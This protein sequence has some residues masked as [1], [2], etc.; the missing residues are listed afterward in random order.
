MEYAALVDVYE[1]LGGTQSTLEKRDVLADAF[2]AADDEH[3]PLLV[4]LVRGHLFAAWRRED[5]DVSSS[6]T[7]RAIVKATGVEES[8]IDDRWRETGDLGDAAAWATENEAQRTLFSADLTVRDVYDTLRELTTY[9]GDGSQ[10]RRI[11]AIAR[12]LSDA[13]PEEARYVTRTAL[14]HLRIGVGD[15]LVRDAIAMAFLDG[16]DEDGSGGDA[17]DSDTTGDDRDDGEF[18][19]SDGSDGSDSGV[20]TDVGTGADTDDAD[21]A[22]AT[23]ASDEAVSDEAIGAVERAFQVTNDYP[24]VARTAENEGLDGLAELGISLFRPVRVMLAE[25]AE[26]LDDGIES[27]AETRESVLSEYKYDG[28]RIQI[29][30]RGEE[31]RIFTRRLEDVTDAFP[32]IVSA[33]REN[34]HAETCVLDGEAVGYDPETGRPVTFQRFSQRIKR[35]YDIEELAEEIPAVVYL[36]DA[37]ALEGDSLLDDPLRERLSALEG[38]FDPSEGTLERAHNER[39]SDPEGT[40]EF[41]EASLEAGHEGVMLKNLDAPY[42]P[43]RRVG[44]VMKAKPTMETLDLLVTRAQYSEGRR[45]DFLGR[46]F[47]ACIDDTGS[48]ADTG[49][50]EHDTEGGGKD[51]SDERFPEV[52]RLATGYTDNELRELTDRLEGL[53]TERR[54]QVFDVAPEVVLEIEYEEIQP[55]TKYGS[56]YALRFPRFLGVREDLSPTDVDPL[57]RVEHLYDEQ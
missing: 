45:S 54:G 27:V 3:L 12:L 46:L 39:V 51:E 5:L 23:G 11:D 55:S 10:R 32:D 56:G 49:D 44:Y 38:L 34:V 20:G 47:L 33:V 30:K 21:D 17:D 22:D 41:Y 48:E 4:T 43:G 25:K 35:K 29:H 1:H 2:A 9:E 37:L 31:V 36:F 8:A 16:S 19:G 40:R 13:T 52:G 7:K 26:G 24:L 53:L 28:V 50:A 6:L 57:S 42:Q 18:D 14:G 15:G